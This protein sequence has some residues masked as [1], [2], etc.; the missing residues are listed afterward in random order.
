MIKCVRCHTCGGGLRT[1]LDGEE[2]CDFCAAY[3]RYRSHGWAAGVSEESPCPPSYSPP[4]ERICPSCGSKYVGRCPLN[5]CNET[6][7]YPY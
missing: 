7:R 6:E 3:R 1:V 5:A 2:W 4:L